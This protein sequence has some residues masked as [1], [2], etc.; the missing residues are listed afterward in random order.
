M[1]WWQP[2]DNISFR[3]PK[4]QNKSI[5]IIETIFIYFNLVNLCCFKL[6]NKVFQ[7]YFV[8]MIRLR[9]RWPFSQQRGNTPPTHKKKDCF[10][11]DTNLASDCVAPFQVRVDTPILTLLPVPLRRRMVV[12][13]MVPSMGQGNSLK[14]ID[15][16]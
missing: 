6:M 2:T 7:Y 3:L 16:W 12:L 10:G 9:I 13:I 4:Y 15:I 8:Q 14:V 1:T 5:L 11:Y